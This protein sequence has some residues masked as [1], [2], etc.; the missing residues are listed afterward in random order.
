MESPI[1]CQFFN[2]P[3]LQKIPQGY[4]QSGFQSFSEECPWTHEGSWPGNVAPQ[5]NK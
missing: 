3:G 4:L 2:K 1:N 5:M